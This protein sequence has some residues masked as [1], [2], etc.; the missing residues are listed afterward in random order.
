MLLLWT[1]IVWSNILKFTGILAINITT[2]LFKTT[3]W[4]P[5]LFF[6]P[7]LKCTHSP[8][9]CFEIACLLYSYFK[10]IFLLQGQNQNRTDS[11]IIKSE[12]LG[13][14][15]SAHRHSCASQ[16]L[17]WSMASTLWLL[18]GH[19]GWQTSQSPGDDQWES[20][21]VDVQWCKDIWLLTWGDTKLGKWYVP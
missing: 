6:Y 15:Q 5:H 11:K 13:K 7:N 17:V 3:F 8:S 14:R 12:D 9:K 21:E 2:T 10:T 16:G 18:T 1:L 4:S 19:G 20:G